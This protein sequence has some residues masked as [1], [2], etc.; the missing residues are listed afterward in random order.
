MVSEGTKPIQH[1]PPRV[2]VPPTETE[3]PSPSPYHTTVPLPGCTE[4]WD[5][6]LGSAITGA[7]VPWLRLCRWGH[8]IPIWYSLQRSAPHQ[9]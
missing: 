7:S 5:V 9:L 8:N 6:S 2:R 3:H 1:A 4:R